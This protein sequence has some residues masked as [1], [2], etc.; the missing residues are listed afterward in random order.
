MLVN[1]YR[2]TSFCAIHVSETICL[3]LDQCLFKNSV[4]IFKNARSIHCLWSH[5]DPLVKGMLLF[6]HWVMSDSLWLHGLHHARLLCPPL[7]PLKL[8]QI[9]VH[10]VGNTIWL[11]HPLPPPSPFAF[12][13]S[14]HQGL[15]QWKDQR[16]G[17]SVSASVFPVNI[18]GWFPLGLTGLISLQSKGLS[19]GI[20]ILKYCGGWNL[21][22]HMIRY[23]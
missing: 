13:L 12:N 9:H 2:L 16:I 3:Y 1:Q 5:G 22:Y 10:W 14:Q 17:A 7:S 23:A 21:D 4:K 18:Q 11:S 8:D 6:I 15:F 20:T 19:K